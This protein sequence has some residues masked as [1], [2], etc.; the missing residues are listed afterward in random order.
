MP[1]YR[2]T[3]KGP[4]PVQMAD[5]DVKS[6]SGRKSFHVDRQ[7]ELSPMLQQMK[8]KGIAKFVREDK[9][10]VVEGDAKSPPREAIATPSTPAPVVPS[11]PETVP[12]APPSDSPGRTLEFDADASAEVVDHADTQNPEG[13]PDSSESGASE[14]QSRNGSTDDG[15][16]RK[17]RRSK[18]RGRG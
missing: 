15:S 13:E 12:D 17:K 8:R 16:S 6:F 1:I 3:Q 9:P 2:N 7:T 18:R 5:G 14:S 4:L 10:E 11:V